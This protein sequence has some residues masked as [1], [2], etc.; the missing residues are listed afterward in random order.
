MLNVR[1]VEQSTQRFDMLY[2]QL[3]RIFDVSENRSNELDRKGFSQSSEIG[4]GFCKATRVIDWTW[5]FSAFLNDAM[6]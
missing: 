2:D 3:I 4:N 6:G 5:Q 1:N